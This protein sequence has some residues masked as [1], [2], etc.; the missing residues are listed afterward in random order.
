MLV[1][2]LLHAVVDPLVVV[3]TSHF[4]RKS[5]RVPRQPALIPPTSANASGEKFN[6]RLVVP[7]FFLSMLFLGIDAVQSREPSSL[8]DRPPRHNSSL[9]KDF[10]NSDPVASSDRTQSLVLRALQHVTI[11][12][13]MGERNPLAVGITLAG[14]VKPRISSTHRR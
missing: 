9:R 8:T 13:P 5:S 1:V 12:G 10:L 3:A 4:K 14:A 7:T 11:Y 6:S 2:G